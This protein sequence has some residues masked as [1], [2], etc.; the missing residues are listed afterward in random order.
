M[1]IGLK[2]WVWEDYAGTMVEVENV[3]TVSTTVLIVRGK[4]F[5]YESYGVNLLNHRIIC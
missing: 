4:I 1:F 3:I 2:Q 5:C